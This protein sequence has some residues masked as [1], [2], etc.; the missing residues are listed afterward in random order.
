MFDSLYLKEVSIYRNPF[1]V[2]G[3]V[4]RWEREAME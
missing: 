2:S 3:V 1:R 4:L